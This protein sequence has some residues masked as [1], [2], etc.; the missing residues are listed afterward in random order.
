MAATG[1][2]PG[3][4]PNSA[5]RNAIAPLSS[6]SPLRLTATGIPAGLPLRLGLFQD[7][8]HLL[9]RGVHLRLH[10]L[11]SQSV[12]DGNPDNVRDLG[13]GHAGWVADGPRVLHL[14]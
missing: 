5:E 2:S 3:P 12:V 8:G 13:R 6:P 14:R 7:I 4:C 11:A 1:E 10:V 9:G